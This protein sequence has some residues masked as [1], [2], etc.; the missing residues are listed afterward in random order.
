MH[1]ESNWIEE[2]SDKVSY[3]K[4]QYISQVENR[5]INVSNKTWKTLSSNNFK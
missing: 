2:A 5:I 3:L 4:S 1:G